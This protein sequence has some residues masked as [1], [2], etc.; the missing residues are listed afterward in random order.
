MN[1]HPD[2]SRAEILWL[3]FLEAREIAFD[4]KRMDDAAI[5]GKAWAAFLNEFV[6]EDHKSKLGSP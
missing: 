2:K 6:N 5:A 1:A 4:T 3:D